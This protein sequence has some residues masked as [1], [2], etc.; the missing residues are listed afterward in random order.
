V[1]LRAH[2]TL[3]N[4]KSKLQF[5]NF[6]HKRALANLLRQTFTIFTSLNRSTKD[7]VPNADHLASKS[8]PNGHSD[9][10][11]DGVDM[12]ELI[13]E[14]TPLIH[15]ISQSPAHRVRHLSFLSLTAIIYFAVS[16]GPEGTENLI[17]SGGPL[18]T[19]IGICLTAVFWALPTALM[20]TELS[21]AFPENGGFV[22]WAK[23]AW[24]SAAGSL[25]GWLQ[26][27]S[28]AVDAALYP[29][30]FFS[31]VQATTGQEYSVYVELAMRTCFVAVLILLNVAGLDAVGTSSLI[32][33]LLLLLP[34]VIII[35]IASTGALGWPTYTS[36]WLEILPQACTRP[37]P[38]VSS[39]HLLLSSAVRRHASA[40][41][42]KAPA[43]THCG[44]KSARRDA[45][46]DAQRVSRHYL[47]R[48]RRR[49]TGAAS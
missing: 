9:G 32:M 23:T 30:M 35:G 13:T 44:A 29:A 40:V 38:L 4:K 24:G 25:A 15:D 5:L 26:F 43:S 11:T 7:E 49:R 18:F 1:I 42:H 14:D 37:S 19:I 2:P 8:A 39:P 41:M 10:N 16:G 28:T 6:L 3:K 31:Y 34:Y 20:T 33:L 21:T 47:F 22:I 48:R 17:S 36:N 46:R 27:V 12:M 45:Q